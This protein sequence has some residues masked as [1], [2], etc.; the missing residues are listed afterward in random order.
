MNKAEYHKI[1]SKNPMTQKDVDKLMGILTNSFKIPKPEADFPQSLK[2][3]DT[4]N[5]TI[6][7][8]AHCFCTICD[9]SGECEN[10]PCTDLE[11]FIY[12]LNQLLTMKGKAIYQ[13]VGKAAEYAQWACNFY[14][15]CSNDCTYCYCKRGVMAHTWSDTPKLKACFKNEEHALEVFEKEL[16]ANLQELQKHGLF[17]TFTSDPLLPETRNLTYK[18]VSFCIKNYVPVKLL[19]KRADWL[20]K[21]VWSPDCASFPI[22]THIDFGFTLTGH[23]ELEPNASTNAE[24][25]E[26][27][28]KLHEAGFKTWASIE[29]IIDVNDSLRMISKTARLKICDLYKIGLESGKKYNKTLLNNFIKTT[30][31]EINYYGNNAKIYFKDSLLSQAGINREDL[32]VNCVTRDYNMFN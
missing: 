24:R 10:K 13:P 28:R 6:D 19:T 27:M 17:F 4:P 5:I 14:T 9:L 18:A 25:I 2:W 12:L 32:P 1:I 11:Q 21:V 30:I 15:G 16:K 7:K 26:A 20:E 31:Y 22:N 8:A 3:G 29:P 23:D